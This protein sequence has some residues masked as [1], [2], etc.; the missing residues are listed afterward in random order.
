MDIIRGRPEGA[1]SSAR[2]EHF[3]GTVWSDPVLR[4]AEDVRVEEHWHGAS[5]DSCL[6]H[7]AV[8][9]GTTEWRAAVT[10]DECE[11]HTGRRGGQARDDA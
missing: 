10:D 1:T 11:E 9:L 8:S 3:T 7:Y 5:G 4:T 6:V 2:S